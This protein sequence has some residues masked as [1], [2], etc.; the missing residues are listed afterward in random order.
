[1]CAVSSLSGSAEQPNLGLKSCV[2]RVVFPM[3]S[4]TFMMCCVCQTEPAGHCSMLLCASRGIRQHNS[5]VNE[6]VKLQQWSGHSGCRHVLVPTY[7]MCRCD[8]Q[9]QLLGHSGCRAIAFQS[10]HHLWADCRACG[11]WWIADLRF[12]QNLFN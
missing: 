9:S 1:M 10:W 7:L 5:C 2:T 12:A 3:C 6:T 4:D 11:A 8:L